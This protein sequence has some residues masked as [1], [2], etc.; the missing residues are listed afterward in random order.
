MDFY[1]YVP[2]RQG[3]YMFLTDILYNYLI[4]WNELIIAGSMLT[5]TEDEEKSAIYDSYHLPYSIASELPPNIDEQK[6]FEIYSHKI[7]N[8]SWYWQW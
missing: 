6:I 2:L 3:V 7:M 4:N 8:D 5:N 1:M